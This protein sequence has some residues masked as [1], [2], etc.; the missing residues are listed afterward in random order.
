MKINFLDVFKYT[1]FRRISN[2][3][4]NKT[5]NKAAKLS[6]TNTHDLINQGYI[7]PNVWDIVKT[8][9][10]FGWVM[11]VPYIMVSFILAAFQWLIAEYIFTF[12]Y[13]IVIVLQFFTNQVAYKKK[14]IP[15]YKADL[16]NKT[17]QR[18]IG[19]KIANDKESAI[20]MPKKGLIIGYITNSIFLLYF[21][22]LGIPIAYK[23][24]LFY[25]HC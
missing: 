18:Q 16:R 7:I 1:I 10:F 15:I 12:L 13:F 20:P 24:Y 23:I 17:G 19:N 21:S 25:K 8:L 22:L 9:F 4:I 11:V 6:N 3:L 5:I 14:A 2:T